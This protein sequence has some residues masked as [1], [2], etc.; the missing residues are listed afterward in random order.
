MSAE[1]L[2]QAV[3]IS[4]LDH[5][6][7]RQAIATGSFETINGTVR[8]DGVENVVTPTAFVQRQD[9]RMHLVWPPEIATAPLALR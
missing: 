2:Q 1:I 5:D 8:F 6:A 7:L 4:G 9:G 3:A